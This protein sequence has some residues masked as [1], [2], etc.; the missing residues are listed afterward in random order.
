[1]GAKRNNIMDKKKRFCKECFWWIG[2]E[3][4]CKDGLCT[5]DQ[6]NDIVG[7]FVDCNNEACESFNE[8]KE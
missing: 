6:F 5:I 4:E 3:K 7:F 1:M 8:Y 2:I